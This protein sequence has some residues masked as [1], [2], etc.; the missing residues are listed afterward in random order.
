ML[1]TQHLLKRPS[2]VFPGDSEIHFIYKNSFVENLS[3]K[4]IYE[5]CKAIPKEW[6]IKRKLGSGSYASVYEICNSESCD[7]AIK[8]QKND[9]SFSEE[10]RILKKLENWNHSPKMYAYWA[11]KKKGYI[12]EEK[13]YPLPKNKN[14]QD[15]NRQIHK[16]LDELYYEYKI[17]YADVHSGNFLVNKENQIVVIDFGLSR[18]FKNENDLFDEDHVLNDPYWR[19]KLFEPKTGP[20]TVKMV[21]AYQDFEA[22]K[23]FPIEQS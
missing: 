2:P 23:Y 16:I 10:V 19:K 12:V 9:E 3:K 4:F 11:C 17:I 6:K 18:I 20:L 22:K 7:Y 5:N 21:K 14:P 8:Q 1:Q 15:F 13:L